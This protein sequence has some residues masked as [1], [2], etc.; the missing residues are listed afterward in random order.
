MQGLVAPPVKSLV[1]NIIGFVGQEGKLSVL[2]KCFYNK[3]E[4]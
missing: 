3:I 1:V 2:N 4:K